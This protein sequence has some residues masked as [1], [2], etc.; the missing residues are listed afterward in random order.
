MPSTPSDRALVK[1]ML[2]TGCTALDVP[3]VVRSISQATA[4]RMRRNWEV[5]GEVRKPREAYTVGRKRRITAGVLE[6]LVRLLSENPDLWQEEVQE[7]LE[8]E[9]HVVVSRRTVG[10]A[11]RSIDFT[12]KVQTRVAAQ[13]DEVARAA[14]RDDLRH[15]HADN[16][17]FV[18]E[19][20]CAEHT[21]WRRY[22]YSPR[23]TPA[24]DVRLKKRGTRWSVLPALT[25][26]G[27]ID[28]ATVVIQGSVTA[29]VYEVWLRDMLLPLLQRRSQD[30]GRIV[31]LVMDNCGTHRKQQ[32]RSL[33]A[34]FAVVPLWLPTYSPDLNPIE[35]TFHLFK[36]WLKRHRDDAPRYGDDDYQQRF[37]E[38]LHRGCRDFGA[39]VDF[40]ELFQR[41]SCSV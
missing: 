25:T 1:A 22:G 19:S 14:W 38:Y 28:G 39:G 3:D 21:L 27:Y 23:G 15:I 37:S 20:A 29:E 26:E 4:Y 34:A 18:D 12:R 41:C 8:L 32:V 33:C 2:E 24:V 36:H 13:R 6:D 35:L 5:F 31:Y 17:V 10:R 30:S 9:H 7:Y 16:M 40:R 11:I